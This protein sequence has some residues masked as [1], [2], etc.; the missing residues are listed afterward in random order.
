MTLEPENEVG[1]KLSRICTLNDLLRRSGIGGQTVITHGISSLPAADRDTILAKVRE[2]D[3]F[4]V[5]G[6][7][8]DEHNFGAVEHRGQ[9]VF[10]KIDY[11]DQS[12]EFLSEDPSDQ[13][14]TCRVLTILLSD[15]Y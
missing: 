6:D 3:E 4:D 9:T 14:K 10:F 2:Y 1:E 15:E 11:Y 8:S 12:M 5:D 13:A 7:L